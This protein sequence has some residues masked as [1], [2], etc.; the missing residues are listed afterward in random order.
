MMT[1]MEATALTPLQTYARAETVVDAYLM[2]RGVTHGALRD[3]TIDQVA[4]AIRRHGLA[5][6]AKLV[7]TIANEAAVW[8]ANQVDEALDAY[9][10]AG[11]SRGLVSAKRDPDPKP[12]PTA[13]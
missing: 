9:H 2:R 6:G 7:E 8:R 11:G 3:A 5:E 1:T 12:P 13:A 10:A 4:R